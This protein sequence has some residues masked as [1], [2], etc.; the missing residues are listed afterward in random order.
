MRSD[1]RPRR[2]EGSAAISFDD[3]LLDR[4]VELAV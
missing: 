2:P 3:E 1:V 4:R